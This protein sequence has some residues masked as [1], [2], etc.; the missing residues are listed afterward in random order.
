MAQN[1]SRFSQVTKIYQPFSPF[2]TG[3]RQKSTNLT[4]MGISDSILDGIELSKKNYSL[5][6]KEENTVHDAIILSDNIGSTSIFLGAQILAVRDEIREVTHVLIP[7]NKMLSHA[8]FKG[9]E[10]V[11]KAI[12][13]KGK[14][15]RAHI[16]LDKFTG[17]VYCLF[18]NSDG[19][20]FLDGNKVDTEADVVDFPF[21]EFSQATIGHVPNLS[22]SYG[23]LF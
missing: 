15:N 22:K 18:T 17:E 2:G 14:V 10:L 6:W 8:V 13:H 3:E 1:I 16:S 9:R 20:L 7:D 5:N 12:I 4:P 23:I 21:M 19:Q 11:S